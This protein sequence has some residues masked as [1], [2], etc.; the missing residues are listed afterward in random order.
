MW[1]SPELRVAESMDVLSNG[2]VASSLTPDRSTGPRLLASTPEKPG[3]GW[4]SRPHST[5]QN[6][7]SLEGKMQHYAR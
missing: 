5:R 3:S 7:N 6:N 1:V 4:T 2:Y